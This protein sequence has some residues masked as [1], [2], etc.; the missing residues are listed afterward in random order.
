M[1]ELTQTVVTEKCDFC[2]DEGEVQRAVIDGKTRDGRWAFM[3]FRHYAQ[4]GVGLGT[5]KGQIICRNSM[6]S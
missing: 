2:Q 6:K 5:G 3:C 1:Q 4:H